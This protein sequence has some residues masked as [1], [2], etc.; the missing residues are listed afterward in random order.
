MTIPAARPSTVTSSA[1]RSPASS[2]TASVTASSAATAGNGGSMTSMTSAPSRC[3]LCDRV[4]Q[5]ARLADAADDRVRVVRGDDRQLRD[6]VL[7]EQRDR[8]ADL[9]VRLDGDERRDE[10]VL[11]LRAQD[12]ADGL[13]G[14]ALEEAVLAHP[15]VVVDL[16]EVASGRRRGR[17]PR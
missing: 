9:V 16:R 17:S 11:G 1:W 14:R 4:A 6:A 2:S 3:G 15:R 8:V 10:A 7:V 13:V 12:V 5:Q